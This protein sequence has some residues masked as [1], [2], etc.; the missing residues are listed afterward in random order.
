M[1]GQTIRA[2]LLLRD[3]RLV[4]IARALGVARPTVSQVVRG[5]RKSRRIQEYIADLLDMPVEDI[6]PP[7]NY[8]NQS[9]KNLD[10]KTSVIEQKKNRRAG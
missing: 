5:V 7:Q 2:L 8:Q 4:D 3:I 1:K 6:W 9:N 10:Q